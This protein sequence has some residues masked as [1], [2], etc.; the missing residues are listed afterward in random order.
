M[1]I[2][3]MLGEDDAR[4]KSQTLQ[5]YKI[6]NDPHKLMSLSQLFFEFG[7]QELRLSSELFDELDKCQI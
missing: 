7:I 1:N 2:Q 6:L 5:T 3:H 4:T